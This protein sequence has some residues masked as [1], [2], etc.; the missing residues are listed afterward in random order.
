[1]DVS[2]SK[3]SR[4]S[5]KKNDFEF[6]NLETEVFFLTDFIECDSNSLK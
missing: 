1:M 3:L 5:V 6:L 2:S 4:D